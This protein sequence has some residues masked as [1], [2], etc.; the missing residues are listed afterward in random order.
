MLAAFVTPI[1][2]FS[3]K[4]AKDY[5]AQQSNCSK[6]CGKYVVENCSKEIIICGDFSMKYKGKDYKLPGEANK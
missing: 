4:D 3:M 1:V 2:Y 6:F 5:N